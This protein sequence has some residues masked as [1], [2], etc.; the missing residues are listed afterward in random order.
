M[1]LSVYIH[2]VKFLDRSI[3]SQCTGTPEELA[4]QLGLSVSTLYQ[5]LR[6][7]RNAG[8]PIVYSKQHKTYLYLYPVEFTYGFR[9]PAGEIPPVINSS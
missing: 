7:M 5:Y 3:R 4:E 2:R 1:Q 6:A 9:L 8:A